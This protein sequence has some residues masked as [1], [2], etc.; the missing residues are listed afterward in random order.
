MKPIRTLPDWPRGRFVPF[1]HTSEVL[2]DN[3]WSDPTERIVNVYLPPDY[4]PDGPRIPVIWYLA[5]YTNSGRTASNWRGFVENIGE[6]ADRLRAERKLGPVAIVA[7]DCFTSLGGNQY[8]DSEAVGAYASYIHRE[9]IP[10]VE[11]AFR[12]GGSRERR[13]VVGKSSGGFGAIR[14]GMDFPEYWAAVGDQSGDCHFEVVLRNGFAEAAGVLARHGGDLHAFLKDFWSTTNPRGSDFHTLM[15]ICLAATYDPQPIKE[16]RLPFDLETLELDPHRWARWLAH[17]PI[18]R[19]ADRVDALRG[20][21]AIYLDCGSQDQ[22]AIH[23]GMRLLARTLEQH[24]IDHHYEEFKG[25]HSGI[26]WRLD[27]SL[28]YL[29]RAIAPVKT[30]DPA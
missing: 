9:L 18:R 30:T 13:A 23:F 17:D 22:Y 11:A 4:D 6:R 21:R 27:V 10:A 7:P 3:P 2:R 26:D 20:L 25:S 19:V 15:N 8:V 16:L 28:P 14:F 12:I 24:G 5:A 1:E 29:Y